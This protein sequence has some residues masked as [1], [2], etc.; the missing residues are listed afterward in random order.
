MRLG[1]LPGMEERSGGEVVAAPGQQLLISP[2]T[3][4]GAPCSN[5]LSLEPVDAER[6]SGGTDE[7]QWD[8]SGSVVASLSPDLDRDP[9]P[10]SSRSSTSSSRCAARSLP[11][12]PRSYPPI[13]FL[14][15]PPC[16]PPPAPSSTV[17]DHR[18]ESS[19]ST[20]TS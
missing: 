18:V 8:L 19:P 12:S 13:P 15:H 3:A 5:L 20:T 10:S 1:L 11:P 17:H 9:S 14:H 2:V 6:A 7:R 4:T 16:P